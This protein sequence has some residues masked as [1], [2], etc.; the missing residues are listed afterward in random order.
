ML[1]TIVDPVDD[2]RQRRVFE[3]TISVRNRLP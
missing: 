2:G 1:G 3:M